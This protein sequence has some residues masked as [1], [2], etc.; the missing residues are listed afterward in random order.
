MKK[1]LFALLNL[2]MLLASVSAYAQHI[3]LKADVPF[4]FVVTGGTVPKGEYEIRSESDVHILT[5]SGGGQKSSSF[6]ANPCLSLKG[7][8]ASQ[9]TKLVFV[10][11]GDQYFLSEIWMKGNGVGHQ[12]PKSRREVEVAQNKTAEQVIVL[13]QLR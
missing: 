13:A 9:Q 2:G 1:K 7:M 4:N 12:L 10:R 6:L 11:Y 5:I 8:E 3:K